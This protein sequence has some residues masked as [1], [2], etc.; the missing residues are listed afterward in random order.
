M[1][2]ER[3][4]NR[5]DSKRRQKGKA[6]LDR[7]FNEDYYVP[8]SCGRK[9]QCNGKLELFTKRARWG[10]MVLAFAGIL[11]FGLFVYSM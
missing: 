4:K 7:V 9:C 2:N 5:S 11:I 8:R 1:A 6:V 3:N 10:G